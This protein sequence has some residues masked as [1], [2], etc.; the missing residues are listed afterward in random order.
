MQWSAA[1]MVADLDLM[2]G[3]KWG[4]KLVANLGLMLGL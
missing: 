1:L 2:L 4:N 3:E